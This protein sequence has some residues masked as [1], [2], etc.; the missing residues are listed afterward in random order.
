MMADS[1]N[2]NFVPSHSN[3]THSGPVRDLLTYELPN[4]PSA[5]E[6]RRLRLSVKT[7]N[8][9]KE[10]A[11]AKERYGNLSKRIKV[12]FSGLL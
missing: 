4:Q 10:D 9:N 6:L 12:S 1:W 8:T 7:R 5:E 11:K 3:A 2:L